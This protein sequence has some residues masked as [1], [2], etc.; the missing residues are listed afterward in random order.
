MKNKK[1]GG[2]TGGADRIIPL[3]Y[4]KNAPDIPNEQ[5]EF[6]KRDIPKEGFDIRKPVSSN[7]FQDKMKPLV[8]LQVY[9]QGENK[10]MD[11]NARR[12]AEYSKYAPIPVYT[13]PYVP[14]QF[15][16]GEL[17]YPFNMVGS[18]PFSFTDNP[19]ANPLVQVIKEYKI[20]HEPAD[21]HAMS[22]LYEDTMPEKSFYGSFNTAGERKA[23]Y[24]F[25]RTMFFRNGD[26]EDTSLSGSGANS[27]LK[28]LK[29]LKLNPYGMEKYN[30]N[31]YDNDTMLIYRT[32]YPIRYEER[33]FIQC[34]RNSVSINVRIYRFYDTL[35][36]YILN[37]TNFY[38]ITTQLIKNFTCPH[39]AMFYGYYQPKDTKIDFNQVK[40][41]IGIKP[42]AK[43]PYDH[44]GIPG[45]KEECRVILTESPTYNFETWCSVGY[46]KDGS[47][48]KQSRTGI[49][50]EDVW[51]SIFFQL[52]YSIYVLL[53]KHI[54]IQ[55][56]KL[57]NIFIKD[58]QQQS[59]VYWKYII[60][61]IEYYVPNC[62]YVLLIDSIGDKNQSITIIPFDEGDKIKSFSSY[63]NF[64]NNFVGNIRTFDGV[65]PLKNL[66]KYFQ[67]IPDDNEEHVFEQIRDNIFENF[68]DN[69]LNNR[70][71]TPLTN[72]EIQ[73]LLPNEPLDNLK[74][75]VMCVKLNGRDDYSFVWFIE[76]NDDN[77]V[78]ID[79]IDKKYIKQT[80]KQSI[81]MKYSYPEQIQQNIKPN[82]PIVD[83]SKV[84]ETYLI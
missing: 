62:G 10:Q 3:Y 59:I 65:K 38:E 63:I 57:L 41:I 22:G 7:I 16:T 20:N 13:T 42:T 23:N 6:R 21:I 24:D 67:R 61:N 66:D 12:L 9:Q 44:K 45:Y 79:K 18:R 4:P 26:G 34:A 15:T 84:I 54:N 51:N 1:T 30:K 76:K 73:N 72:I 46:M 47:T 71:G 58:T 32:C 56:I 8:D 55:D 29:F 68:K 25:I 50:I 37:E 33:A 60:D 81:L 19:S 11:K 80:V 82:E 36:E 48:S 2:I 70:I 31:P 74:T 52:M 83:E 28:R 49:H 53:K 17:P 78:I 69:Y 39:F 40:K 27:L 14:P 43:I 5:K 64:W 75:G 35:K 77:F